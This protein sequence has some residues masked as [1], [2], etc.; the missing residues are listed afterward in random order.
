MVRMMVALIAIVLPGI[1]S[2]PTSTPASILHPELTHT[3]KAK[4]GTCDPCGASASYSEAIS[5]E[6]GV[7]V[8]TVT[9]S[10]C[11]NHYSYCTGKSATSGCGGRGEEGTESQA[12]DME[13]VLTF[14]AEPVIA[15]KTVNVSCTQGGIGYALNGIPFYSGWVSGECEQLD[16]TNNKA[17]WV[18]FDFCS[19]HADGQTGMYHYH[20]PPSCL[21][22]QLSSL[23]RGYADGHSPQVGWA[24]DGFPIYGP[25]GPSGL[26]MTHTN[27]GCTTDYCLDECGGL[28]AEL[29][30]V[31]NFKY[32]YC[33]S[34]PS[35]PLDL[36]VNADAFDALSPRSRFLTPS[37]CRHDGPNVRPLLA[38]FG[39]EA[40]GVRLSLFPRLPRGLHPEGDPKWRGQVQHR[41]QPGGG[42]LH[43][44]IRGCGQ[45]RRLRSLCRRAGSGSWNAVQ[46]AAADSIAVTATAAAVVATATAT[47]AVTAATV[48][49]AAAVVAAATVT[50]AA[51]IAAAAGRR[52]QELV[53]Y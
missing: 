21:I 6:D 14:P 30:E 9:T 32:R 43:E 39:P 31:D 27:Q 12:D 24:N 3:V 23:G 26:Y 38:S 41:P 19:G 5:E 45:P 47:A 50:T 13:Y 40:C 33:A 29:S 34:L 48:A 52:V 46:R 11:P 36:S 7:A 53:L 42:G 1:F 8:R 28:Y 17:E 15:S 16:V 51:V 35:R 20:F 4:A 10:G 22:D 2:I 18:S 37:R 44:R 49:A 25:Y